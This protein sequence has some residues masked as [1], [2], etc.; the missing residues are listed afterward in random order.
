MPT[1]FFWLVTAQFLS[2]IADNALLIVT[3]ALLAEQ[4]YAPWWAPA[5]K[6]AFTWS[7][8]LLAP[9]VGHVADG[10][11]KRHLMAYTNGLKLLAAACMLAGM[12]PIA[13]FAVVGLGASLYAPAKYGLMTELVAPKQLIRAN[14]WL[15]VTVVLSVLLGIGLGGWL[16]SEQWL[17]HQTFAAYVAGGSYAVQTLLWPSLCAVV[18]MY[19]VAG[20]VNMG[21]PK[22]PARLPHWR[23]QC[24][25]IMRTFL[26][27]NSK[28]WRDGLGGLSLSVTTIFWGASAVMQFAVLRW[29]SEV[30]ALPLDQAAYLQACVAIGVMVGAALSAKTVQLMRSVRLLPVG[31]VLGVL[32]AIAAWTQTV[33]GA[34]SMLLLVGAA[35]GA[36]VVPM[37]ALLQYRGYRLLSPGVSIAVQGFNENVSILLMLAAYALLLGAGVPIVWL[38]SGFGLLVALSMLVVLW[39][40][41][42]WYRRAG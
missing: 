21:V 30:L 37:N 31:I 38:M 4:G 15:E 33:G 17:A 2:G 34:L 9:L 23:H 8:V 5:L 35:G 40:S 29:A 1:G 6:L 36:L 42:F 18:A 10:C 11:I 12:N 22:L 20:A 25:E 13:A 16:V 26:L 28:L 39:R 24:L 32:V 3:M 27:A 19:A 7:Y 14:G 41:R